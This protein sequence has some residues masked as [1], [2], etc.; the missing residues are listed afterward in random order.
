MTDE[1][2]GEIDSVLRHIPR[3]KWK[4]LL[5]SDEGAELKQRLEAVRGA[6]RAAKY[7]SIGQPRR[8][9]AELVEMFGYD[10]LSNREMGPWLREQLLRHALSERDWNRLAKAFRKIGRSKARELHGNS[11]QNGHGSTTMAGY[12]WRGSTW[13]ETFCKELGLPDCLWQSRRNTRPDDEMLQRPIP[14]SPLHDFQREAYVEL[15]ELLNKGRGRTSVLSLP[16]GAGKTRVAVEAVCDHLANGGESERPR[17]VL[18]LAQSDELLQQ[19]WECFRQ[20]WTAPFE[21]NDGKPKNRLPLSMVRAWGGRH[22]EDVQ[23][24]EGPSVVLASIQQ[25]NGW[26][27]SRHR[28][29]SLLPRRQMV[30]AIIDEAHRVLTPVHSQ[31][32]GA[33]DLKD[34]RLWRPLNGS[35]PVIGLTATPW[36]SNEYEAGSLQ[37]Y[38]QGSLVGPGI[39]GP[40]PVKRLQSLGV[41]GRVVGE[42]L[43]AGRAPKLTKKQKAYVDQYQELPQDYLEELGRHNPRNGLIL[44]R[45]LG[46]SRRRRALVFACS[47]E[48]AETLA[49]ALNRAGGDG[50]AG[51][52]TGE[53]PIAARYAMIQRFRE[54]KLRFLCNVSVL[55]TGFDAPKADTV[56]VT[57]PT[58]SSLLY[59]QMVGRGLRGPSNG[60][61]RECLV[62]D[63]QD[64]GLPTKVLS[65]ERVLQEWKNASRSISARN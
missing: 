30:A 33:L 3:R 37:R 7:P 28:L 31:V 25:L 63:V 2:R 61:T 50:T 43:R 45:L 19:T 58:R 46:L 36:R 39:L 42:P 15:C 24:G 65:Y 51:V 26:H 16:T 49:L 60:G 27:K 5:A 57:R 53:T 10:L 64:A 34:E 21:P 4:K 13:A 47:V 12:W 38:F 56:V 20:V 48:H 52:V 17:F 9:S 1:E 55:T 44:R 62:I 18:W 40:T 11:T 32:L 14:L 8:P 6:L 35:P 41:L 59:E 23:L 29:A 54:G 22:A